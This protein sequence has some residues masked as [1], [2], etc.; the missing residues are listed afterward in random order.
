MSTWKKELAERQAL[1]V[2]PARHGLTGHRAGQGAL[3]LHRALARRQRLRL[4]VQRPV[5]VQSRRTEGEEAISDLE[6]VNELAAV[7]AMHFDRGRQPLAALRHYAEAAEA[8]TA[9]KASIAIRTS[10]R[11]IAFVSSSRRCMSRRIVT[12]QDL[13]HRRARICRHHGTP[14]ARSS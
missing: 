5:A 8:A 4:A 6:G 13:R 11:K 7:L 12:A 3:Q 10:P 14:A 1:L 9:P 2:E